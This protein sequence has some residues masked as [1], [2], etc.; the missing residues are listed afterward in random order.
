[1]KGFSNKKVAQE[2]K[3]SKPRFG[4]NV[5]K[6]KGLSELIREDEMQAEKEIKK[7]TVKVAKRK[8]LISCADCE[9]FV[10]TKVVG[11]QTFGRL[12]CKG[13]CLHL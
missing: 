1:M 3:T 10:L 2:S 12:N 9:M 8:E 4:N 6:G 11:G 5:D 13:H 7:K